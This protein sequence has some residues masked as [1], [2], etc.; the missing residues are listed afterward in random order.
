MG[1]LQRKP[2]KM[3]VAEFGNSSPDPRQAYLDWHCTSGFGRALHKLEAEYLEGLIQL[4]YNQTI[5]QVGRLDAENRFVRQYFERN[6]VVIDCQ[7][8]G[9]SFG[10]TTV[11][12]DFAQLPLPS[13]SVDIVIIPHLLEFHLHPHVILG[14]VERVLKAEGQLFIFGFNPWR[15]ERLSRYVS[16]TD[17]IDIPYALSPYRLLSWMSLL[18]IQTELIA[19]F[20]PLSAHGISDPKTLMGQSKMILATAYL[21]KGIKRIYTMIP[22]KPSLLQAPSLVPSRAIDTPILGNFHETKSY[23]LHRR[24]VQG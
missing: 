12:A 17:K 5:L 24:R 13:E 18:R 21:L 11:T 3:N 2:M 14:E 10:L 16:R 15:M 9:S 23:G 22:A 1:A 19:G 4:T 8:P 20:H 6:H 7:R